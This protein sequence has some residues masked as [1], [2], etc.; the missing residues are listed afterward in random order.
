MSRLASRWILA[1]WG[2]ALTV[3]ITRELERGPGGPADLRVLVGAQQTARAGSELAG[4]I[5]VQVVDRNGTPIA[6]V[7]V[8]F[9]VTRGG[10]ALSGPTSVSDPDGTVTLHWTLGSEAG[11]Q[12][13]EIQVARTGR[14][15]ARIV[16]SVMAHA[17]ASEPPTES[18][19]GEGPT[20]VPPPLPIGPIRIASRYASAV[21]AD[22]PV[23]YWPLNETDGARAL[24]ASGHGHEGSFVE[25]PR[26][27]SNL[28][29]RLGDGIELSGRPDGVVSS[30]TS[31]TNLSSFSVEV[32]ALP[33]RVTYAESA[34]LV[35]KGNGWGLQILA[36][37]RPAFALPF[38][39][40][41]AIAD[42]ALESGQ[43]Y[44]LVGTYEA[45]VISLW[46]DGVL[47]AQDAAAAPAVA[48]TS[49]PIHAGR[50]LSPGGRFQYEGTLGHVAIYPRVL[51]QDRIR[52]HYAAGR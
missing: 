29:P 43:L 39:A 16:R 37:G 5:V 51:S 48:V 23:A 19:V 7:P 34:L 41:R 50:G 44:H 46:V 12:S 1:S 21:L 45:G 32:W 20:L 33:S 24:D 3:L 27:A 30:S 4:P 38:K 40:G 8:V 49:E 14:T 6:G 36:D 42:T 17:E 26:F 22:D 2:I 10:G 18:R 52:A 15:R 13:V 11:D 25:A 9:R 31:W 47:A 35:D 28:G